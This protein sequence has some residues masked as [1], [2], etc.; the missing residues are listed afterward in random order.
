MRDAVLAFFATN[1]RFAWTLV[2][3]TCSVIAGIAIAV[4]SL[5]ST[6]TEK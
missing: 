4:L 2:F 3:A 5:H 1:P 6:P